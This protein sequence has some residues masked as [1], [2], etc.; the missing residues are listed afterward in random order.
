MPDEEIYSCRVSTGRRTYF[1][2]VK[3]STNG[4]MYLVISESRIEGANFRHSRVLIEEE[5]LD[6]FEKG[7]REVLGY[8]RGKRGKKNSA[9]PR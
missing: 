7:F 8:L 6:E 2:D 9:Q 4:D 3:Q 1:F 5:H